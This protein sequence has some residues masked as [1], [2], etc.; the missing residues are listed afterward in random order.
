MDVSTVEAARRAISLWHGSRRLLLKGWDQLW[1]L[2][3]PF[4]KRGAT[5][6]TRTTRCPSDRIATC[7]LVWPLRADSSVTSSFDV[8]AGLS[9][10]TFTSES[11]Y[12]AEMFSCWE[13]YSGKGEE[14]ISQMRSLLMIG[15]LI[16]VVALFLRPVENMLPFKNP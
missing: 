4:S 15:Y 9:G 10:K 14:Q 5:T 12:Q 2:L 11:T 6:R 16:P 1:E 8:A 7:R 3:L 13:P